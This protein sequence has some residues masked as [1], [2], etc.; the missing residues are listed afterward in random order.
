MISHDS[1]DAFTL[2][3][4]KTDDDDDLFFEELLISSSSYRA[5]ATASPRLSHADYAFLMPLRRLY[6]I[7]FTFSIYFSFAA[8][9]TPPRFFVSFFIY[10]RLPR[11]SDA[12]PLSLG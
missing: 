2:F 3:Y 10:F 11:Y 8:T 5:A 9:H 7:I 4:F 1:A 6:V 12:I